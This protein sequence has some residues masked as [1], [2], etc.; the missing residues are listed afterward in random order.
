VREDERASQPRL[1]TGVHSGSSEVPRFRFVLNSGTSEFRNSGS[2]LPE[3]VHV[4]VGPQPG[5]VREIPADVVRIVV[6]RDVIAVPEPVVDIGE[7]PRRDA[8]E[9][10]V[11][12]EAISVSSPEPEWTP[13]PARETPV[14]KGMIEVE[15]SITPAGIVSDPPAIG[16]NVGRVGMPRFVAKAA[17]VRRATAHLTAGARRATVRLTR[18]VTWNESTADAMHAVAAVLPTATTT[19]LPTTATTVLPT[20]STT[21]LCVERDSARQRQ[22]QKSDHWFHMSIL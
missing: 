1:L 21:V 12:K 2:L 13:E 14:L 11:E 15:A 16:V 9:E 4:G 22:R 7:L 17:G 5:V 19:V 8:E 3:I 10:A 6:D 20:A 18:T